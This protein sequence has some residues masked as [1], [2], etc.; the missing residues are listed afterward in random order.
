MQLCTTSE[1]RT[2]CQLSWSCTFWPADCR[3]IASRSWEHTASCLDRA[4]VGPPTVERL[5]VDRENTLPVVLIVHLSVRRLS[6]DCQSIVKTHCQLSWSCTCR[7]A[8]RRTIANRSLT[9]SHLTVNRL[10]ID[11]SLPATAV[12]IYLCFL[13]AQG[14]LRGRP[15]LGRRNSHS[16]ARA[17]EALR[18]ARLLLPHCQGP[19]RGL[20][21]RGG[22]GCGE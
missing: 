19:W 4:L 13:L 20:Q 7:S 12:V 6:N 16:V 11:D 14:V 5:S 15:Q 2:H 8:D 10:S 21:G 1:H 18:G 9:D 17:T 22:R 3:T